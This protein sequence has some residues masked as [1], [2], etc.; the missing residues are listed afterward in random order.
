LFL[1]Q[2]K[3]IIIHF[4]ILKFKCTTI[5]K[6]QTRRKSKSK[7]NSKRARRSTTEE[8]NAFPDNI[9]NENIHENDEEVVEEVAEE[10]ERVMLGRNT[11]VNNLIFIKYR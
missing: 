5:R 2:A 6:R 3:K 11:G 10:L 8:I 9:V 4:S 7:F 1:S